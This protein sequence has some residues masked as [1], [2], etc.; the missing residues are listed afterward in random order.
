MPFWNNLTSLI[1]TIWAAGEWYS[2]RQTLVSTEW[3]TE[4]HTNSKS[5]EEMM[6]AAPIMKDVG[7]GPAYRSCNYDTQ[8]PVYK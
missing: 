2:A 1:T 3:L 7:K 4:I 6:K 8:N 5:L